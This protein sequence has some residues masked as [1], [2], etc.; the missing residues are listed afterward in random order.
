MEK[1]TW[2][3]ARLYRQ[4]GG[5]SAD[6]AWITRPKTVAYRVPKGTPR[7]IALAPEHGVRPCLDVLVPPELEPRTGRPARVGVDER[8]VR[9]DIRDQVLASLAHDVPGQDRELPQIGFGLD[10]LR[11]QLA[12]AE[13]LAVVGHV[14]GRVSYELAQ[15]LVLLGE[16]LGAVASFRADEQRTSL[17][18]DVREAPLTQAPARHRD[19][20]RLQERRRV[21][22]DG[23]RKT[24]DVYRVRMRSSS[25]SLT[26]TGRRERLQR[27][28]DAPEPPDG[29]VLDRTLP[30][31]RPARAW[32]CQR[33][34]RTGSSAR[35][36]A[37]RSGS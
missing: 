31:D 17:V 26:A 3:Q 15:Q 21:V 6:G 4:N 5:R 29:R 16:K 24:H 14:P 9:M 27:A 32:P 10:V 34:A 19:H 25:E 13:H 20:L 33:P 18:V 2:F 7:P 12:V 11:R 36:V 35:P 8:F 37:W 23:L 30:V 1:K 22:V 28:E